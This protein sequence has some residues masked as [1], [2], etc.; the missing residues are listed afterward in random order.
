[1][2]SCLASGLAFWVSVGLA[3]FGA[4]EESGLCIA[5]CTI[6]PGDPAASAIRARELASDLS[7]QGREV[8]TSTCDAVNHGDVTSVGTIADNP[9]SHV[10]AAKSAD[11]KSCHHERVV[12][13]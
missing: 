1:M 6:G 4:W 7:P 8:G 11:L 5:G 3:Q 13:T 12:T 10:C 9:V 2:G